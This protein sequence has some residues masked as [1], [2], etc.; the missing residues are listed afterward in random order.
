LFFTGRGY[1]CVG[2][3]KKL[4]LR[5]PHAR[6][7]AFNYRSFGKSGGKLS[8]KNIF[9]DTLLMAK[10]VQKNYGDFYILG[11][12]L[13]SSVASYVASKHKV[14]GLFLVGVYDSVAG[15][16]KRKFGVDLSMFFRYKF[17]NTKFVKNIDSPT[18]VFVSKSDTTTYIETA[19]ALKGYFKNLVYYVELENLSHDDLLWD[20]SVVEKINK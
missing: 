13:G 1:D 7:V 10:K 8:E 17:D 14:K 4:S 18:Y 15:V 9:S 12:S 6:I 5:F 19:R 3:I 16:A 2:L 20:K 11:F